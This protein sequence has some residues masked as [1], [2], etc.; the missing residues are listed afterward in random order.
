MD[1]N[2]AMQLIVNVTVTATKIPKWASMTCSCASQMH[3]M[4]ASQGDMNLSTADD[5]E[6]DTDKL[7]A[8]NITELLYQLL[9]FEHLTRPKR[10]QQLDAQKL[11]Q[12]VIENVT[13]A[14][15][16]LREQTP[17]IADGVAKLL[18]DYLLAAE[19]II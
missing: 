6:Y 7:K 8:M 18:E 15:D 13:N 1:I 17:L 19:V 12:S 5:I 14:I 3:E 4:A 10:K 2:I 11:Q 9:C 16:G